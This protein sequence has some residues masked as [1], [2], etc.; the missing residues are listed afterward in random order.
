M[1]S[2]NDQVVDVGLDGSFSV[3]VTLE[4]G[5]NVFD[6]TAT[7]ADGSEVSTELTVF[8]VPSP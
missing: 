2:V 8:A 6:I 7:D 3:N 1:F 5:P 4:E